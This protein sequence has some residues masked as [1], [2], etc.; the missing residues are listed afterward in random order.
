MTPREVLLAAAE[1]LERDGWCQGQLW[2]ERGR[3]CASGAILFSS[4]GVPPTPNP[5]LVDSARVMLFGHCPKDVL[6]IP[7]WNDSPGQT[8]ENVIA[9]LRRAASGG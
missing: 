1:L 5:D 8:A 9:T 3:R 2:D 7:H 4:L 6:S